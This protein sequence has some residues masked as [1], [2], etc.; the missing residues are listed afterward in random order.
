MKDKHKQTEVGGIFQRQN[1]SNIKLG[2]IMTAV[3]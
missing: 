3:T 1:E 2:Q